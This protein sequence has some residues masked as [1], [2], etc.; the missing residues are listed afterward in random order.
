M[1]IIGQVHRNPNCEAQREAH[2]HSSN[3][4]NDSWIGDARQFAFNQSFQ[5][6]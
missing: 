6:S 5:D 3:V 1:G 4:L 2:E